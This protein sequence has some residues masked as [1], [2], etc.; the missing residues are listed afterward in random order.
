MANRGEV[1]RAT[2]GDGVRAEMKQVEHMRRW[3]PLLVAGSAAIW[4]Y[5]P[6][7]QE[8]RE[9]WSTDAQYSHCYL[10]P[11]FSAWLWWQRRN[12]FASL[13]SSP[14]WWGLPIVALGLS[15]RQAGAVLYL[16]GVEGLSFLVVLLG[17]VFALGGRQGLAR[18][19]PAIAF[20]VFLLPLPY[21]L[22]TA[23]S[24]PL[25]LLNAQISTFVL[26]TVGLPAAAEG[27]VIVLEKTRVGVVEACN[28][29][30]MMMTFFALAAAVTLVST[31]PWPDRVAVLLCAAPIAVIANVARVSLTAIVGEFGATGFANRFFH[32]MA[33]WFMMPLALAMMWFVLWFLERLFPFYDPDERPI[34][35]L[36][37]QLPGIAPAS[38]APAS[39]RVNMTAE[40]VIVP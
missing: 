38:R 1:V 2:H 30:G 5:W 12:D 29:L 37:L 33:G 7:L 39:A 10:V 18:A 23:L 36:G 6:T 3:L 8:T 21:R 9:R 14:S 17:L 31:R 34:I 26:Q 24:Q 20:L 19:W 28:G 11:L 15:L 22:Q 32:D 4:S 16:G 13:S 40:Q 35:P 25:Q 27:N